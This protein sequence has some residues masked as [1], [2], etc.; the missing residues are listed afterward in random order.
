MTDD[1]SDVHCLWGT[2]RIQSSSYD[3]LEGRKPR[4]DDWRMRR[5]KR[6]DHVLADPAYGEMMQLKIMEDI[7][8]KMM[9]Q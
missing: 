2:S 4:I 5:S 6:G 8:A 3:T 7:K 9:W 1:G